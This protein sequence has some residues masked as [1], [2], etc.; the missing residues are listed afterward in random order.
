MVWPSSRVGSCSLPVGHTWSW[1]MLPPGFSQTSAPPP[2]SSKSC[3]MA[4]FNAM[5]DSMTPLVDC[6][7]L[8]RRVVRP[9]PF[10]IEDE[11]RKFVLL[12]ANV[13]HIVW[14]GSRRGSRRRG[15]PGPLG[16][17]REAGLNSGLSY[18]SPHR[19][20]CGGAGDT[21]PPVL[22]GDVT[23]YPPG[24]RGECRG[25]RGGMKAHVPNYSAAAPAVYPYEVPAVACVGVGPVYGYV[26]VGKVVALPGAKGHRDAR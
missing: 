15:R 20:I 22:V 9:A 17:V 18:D 5:A 3:F 10:H 13:H 11:L 23:P 1:S 24:L 26:G 19:P 21:G 16:C 7:A 14:Q 8:G 2:V 12:P 6:V 25:S 4:R